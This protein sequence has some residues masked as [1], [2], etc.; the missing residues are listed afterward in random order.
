ML[1]TTIIPTGGRALVGGYAVAKNP[2]LARGVSSA[3]FPK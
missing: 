1:A 3:A 2:V